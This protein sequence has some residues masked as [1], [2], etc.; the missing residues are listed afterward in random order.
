[1]L[2]M[3]DAMAVYNVNMLI[4]H[5]IC[6]CHVTTGYDTKLMLGFACFA[7]DVFAAKASK[8]SPSHFDKLMQEFD[9]FLEGSEEKGPDLTEGLARLVNAGMRKRPLDENLKKISAKYPFPGNIP[10][11]QV[12]KTNEDVTKS[13]K[14]GQNIVDHNLK[15]AQLT[16][17]KAMVPVLTWMHDFGTGKTHCPVNN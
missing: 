17:S 4:M 15:K 12:P 7:G 5:L 3:Y 16:L 8:Q 1:M 6:Q 2:C 10:N 11:L 13:L 14:R 9:S